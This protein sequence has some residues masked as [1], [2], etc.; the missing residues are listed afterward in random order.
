MKVNLTIEGKQYQ[1]TLNDLNARPIIAEVNGHYYEVWPEDEQAPT[2]PVRPSAPTPAA[3]TAAAP[4]L[5]VAG[6]LTMKSPL[7]GVII[8][9]DVREGQAVSNGQELYV[10]EAMKKKNSIK[11]DRDV[12]IASIH[13]NAGDTVKHNQ[14]ILTFD[15]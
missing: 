15:G 9:I 11:A 1:V 13:V 7:P 6:S 5:A 12:T 3:P 2:S 10:L 14:P 8:S 4:A